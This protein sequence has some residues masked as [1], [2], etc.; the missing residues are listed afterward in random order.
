MANQLNRLVVYFIIVFGLFIYF[1]SFSNQ[2]VWDDFHFIVKNDAIKSI[3]NCPSFFTKASTLANNEMAY[4]TY[5]PFVALSFS[6]DYLFWKLNPRGYHIE[7]V[8]FHIADAI[9]LF[10]LMRL[11]L[12]NFLASFLI[13]LLFLTHPVQTEV[14]DWI[15]RRGDVLAVF[16]Y[17][18]VFL[19]HVNIK[20]TVSKKAYLYPLMLL[21]FS[22]A[23]LS[24]EIPVTLPLILIFY[25]IFLLANKPSF[26]KYFKYYAPFFIIMIIYGLVRTSV[27]GPII[28]LG[29]WGSGPAT[30][31][32]T[33]CTTFVEYIKILIIP[34]NLCAYR[35]PQI[36][37]SIFDVKLISSIAVLSFIIISAVLLRN[38]VKL[39]TFGIYWFFIS[40][41]LV[42]NI[43]PMGY[44]MSERFLYVPSIGFFIAI[45]GVILSQK[46]PFFIKISYFL[47]IL[48]VSFY[49]I[50]TIERNKDWKDDI[51]L[52]RAIFAVSPDN[53]YMHY[54]LGLAYKEKG[55]LGDAM[56]EFK[57]SIELKRDCAKAFNNLGNIYFYKGRL[58][59]AIA[60]Y[61]KAISLAPQLFE[62]YNNL[63]NIYFKKGNYKMAIKNYKKALILEKDRFEVHDNLAS[64]YV[65]INQTKE[66]IGE[67]ETVL[68]LNPSD[69]VSA[70]R[71]ENLKEKTSG[72]LH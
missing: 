57:K 68:R 72:Q 20:N 16:F 46:N 12:K 49:T 62:P 19:I 52:H 22:M 29:W 67:L 61:E 38:R 14:V 26:K 48:L 53:V 39:F 23:L 5:R 9:L 25:D 2:F 66:A 8:L 70:Q 71:L 63:G 36:I 69:A 10:F 64:A 4:Y 17:L 1:N 51:T 33:M 54:N 55:M 41:V 44:Q 58:D 50:L 45:I 59:D 35:V 40:L 6:V 42:A 15:S 37:Y 30:N 65:E 11:I 18:I 21:F 60:Y 28:E 43:I 7:N 13:S 31:F 34:V 32:F 24:K 56:V 47:L 3:R 27:V